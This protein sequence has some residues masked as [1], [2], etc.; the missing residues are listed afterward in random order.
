MISDCY[1]Y[2]GYINKER[3]VKFK[4]IV[5]KDPDFIHVLKIAFD[6]EVDPNLLK[7]QAELVQQSANE[8]LQFISRR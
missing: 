6:I 4:E 3:F 1:F 8:I 5:E 7:Q 2:L